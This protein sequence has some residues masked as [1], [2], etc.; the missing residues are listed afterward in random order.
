MLGFVAMLVP[1]VLGLLKTPGTLT[2]DAQPRAY[3]LRSTHTT[4]LLPDILLGV[5]LCVC[6]CC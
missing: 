2:G 5:F 3:C 4:A 6:V 1:V